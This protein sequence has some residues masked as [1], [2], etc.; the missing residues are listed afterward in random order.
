MKF[1][2]QTIWKNDMVSRNGAPPPWE[3]KGST[4]A[5]NVT[6]NRTSNDTAYDD[7]GKKPEKVTH[8]SRESRFDCVR[9]QQHANVNKFKGLLTMLAKYKG[10]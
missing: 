7:R 3:R 1:R 6:P 2:E 5:L 10:A 4:N 8:S 9:E